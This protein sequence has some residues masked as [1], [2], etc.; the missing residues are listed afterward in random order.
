MAEH[1]A[2]RGG[3]GFFCT[4]LFTGSDSVTADD[5]KGFFLSILDNK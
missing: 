1:R 5:P 2:E 4:S 3:W